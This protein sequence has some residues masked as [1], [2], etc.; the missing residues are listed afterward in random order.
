M[1]IAIGSESQ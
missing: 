1:G